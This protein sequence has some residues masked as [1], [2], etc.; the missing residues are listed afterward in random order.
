M[1]FKT[2]ENG[3]QGAQNENLGERLETRLSMIFGENGGEKMKTGVSYLNRVTM[4]IENSGMTEIVSTDGN[5]SISIDDLL[6]SIE[7]AKQSTLHLSPS[8]RTEDKFDE[9]LAKNGVTRSYN[10]RKYA[11]RAL[12]EDLTSTE[13]STG[14]EASRLKDL[15]DTIIV[16]RRPKGTRFPGS[17]CDWL[18]GILRDS[19]RNGLTQVI[20]SNGKEAIPI[21]SLIRD[22]TQ[23]SNWVTEEYGNIP[24]SSLRN[25]QT[26]ISDEID[27]KAA[28]DSITSSQG[29]RS[30][31]VWSAIQDLLVKA[32]E[33]G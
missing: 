21:D 30:A 9:I 31:F 28:N 3:N 16:Y 24:L 10:I 1:K 23:V 8:E 27:A 12:I 29:I 25:R 4:T 20:T 19:K 2:F 5:T 22:M 15:E 33:K 17:Q 6:A 11:I 18:I 13:N 32:G 7:G 26:Q 14:T